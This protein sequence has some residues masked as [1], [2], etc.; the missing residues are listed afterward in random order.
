[1]V[2]AAMVQPVIRVL[3]PALL[4]VAEVADPAAPPAEADK[5]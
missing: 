2:Q 1:M 4:A 5:V 3:A